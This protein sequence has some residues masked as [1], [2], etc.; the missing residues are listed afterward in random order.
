M[1]SMSAKLL[2]LYGLLGHTQIGF[3]GYLGISELIVFLTAPF[4]FI[5]D[6][7][8]LK[9]DK[10]STIISLS[11]ATMIGGIVSG[12]VN[13][14]YWIDTVKCFATAYAVF[15]HIVVLHALL[16]RDP[17]ALKWMIVGLAISSVVSIF[18]F[19]SGASRVRGGVA[20]E[21]AA[22]IESVTGYALFWVQQIQTWLTLPIKAWYFQTPTVYSFLV[23]LGCAFY[24]LLSTSS[25]R[26][27]FLVLSF[28]AVLL[29]LGRRNRH[30]LEYLR[31]NFIWFTLIMLIAGGIIG[32]VYKV[33]AQHGVFGVAAQEKYEKQT[34]DRKG[35]LGVL[36]GGRIEFFVAMTAAAQ[37]PILGCGP[38]AEDRTGLVQEFYRK[39]GTSEDYDNYVRTEVHLRSFGFRARRIPAH[40]HI[41]SFWLWY[42]L[43]G[44]VLWIYVLWVFFRFFQWHLTVVP[45][46]FGYFAMMIPSTLWGIFFSPFNDRIDICALITCCLLARGIH[47]RRIPLPPDV[48]MEAWKHA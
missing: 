23:S 9:Y 27:M 7:G 21:G 6:Y 13:H 42:G 44:L 29:F 37:H 39:Y 28:S 33:G 2:F 1:K 45:Q 32:M 16:R 19:Q 20:L 47:A 10:F 3:I 12:W 18:V 38:K 25:G 46:W 26:S 17:V 31:K 11:I 36:M 40:S 22:A 43:P 35:P 41:A 15:A 8:Q 5:R 34:R 14:A 24:A 30:A 4:V 48:A